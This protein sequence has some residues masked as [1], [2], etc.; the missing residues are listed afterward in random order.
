MCIL[1][2]SEIRNWLTQLW[3]L[4]VCHVGQQTQHSGELVVQFQSKGQQADPRK[5]LMQNKSKGSLPENSLQIRQ[6]NL[7]IL[8]RL[9][10]HRMKPTHTMESNLVIHSLLI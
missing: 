4:A 1:F 3:G 9:S 8:L 6:A 10:T 7:F 5:L 2:I